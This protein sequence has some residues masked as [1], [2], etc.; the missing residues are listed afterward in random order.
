MRVLLADVDVVQ[1]RLGEAERTLLGLLAERPT[2]SALHASY[3]DLMF[4][5]L[6]I[7]KGTALA[8]EALR[9]DPH[10]PHALYVAAIG[11]CIAAGSRGEG[12]ALALLVEARPDATKTVLALIT[13]LMHAG[14]FSAAHR[15]AIEILESRPDSEEIQSLVAETE[16]L[17]HWTMVPL[18]PVLRWGHAAQVPIVLLATVVLATV[19]LA[20]GRRSLGNE[21]QLILAA[22]ACAFLLYL[23][24]YP[25]L[26][27]FLVRRRL[28]L[29]GSST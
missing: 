5:A 12:P 7:E 8:A 29:K 25:R 23:A 15:L 6:Q 11:G 3:A 17:S 24:F 4:R 21:G 19:L 20:M 1:G 10:N 28:G 26:L 22:A 2:S 9:L 16:C 18:R 27:R 13:H 14:R